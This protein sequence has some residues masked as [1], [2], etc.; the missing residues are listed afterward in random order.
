[1]KTEKKALNYKSLFIISI[2]VLTISLIAG[3]FFFSKSKKKEDQIEHGLREAK[4]SCFNCNNEVLYKDKFCSECGWT[5]KEKEQEEY[6]VQIERP[7]NYIGFHLIKIQKTSSGKYFVNWNFNAS[8]GDNHTYFEEGESCFSAEKMPEFL[9]EHQEC[10][11]NNDWSG[12]E[13]ELKDNH[14]LV[15]SKEQGED[16][17][18]KQLTQYEFNPQSEADRKEKEAE[19]RKQ[20]CEQRAKEIQAEA[21]KNKKNAERIKKECKERAEKWKKEHKNEWRT[22]SECGKNFCLETEGIIKKTWSSPN[23]DDPPKVEYFC[24][25]CNTKK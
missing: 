25:K 12:W 5:L 17:K 14:L 6:R 16:G 8:E 13:K 3:I 22:C 4:N 15:K 9:A 7:I 24:G 1:M 20:E 23:Y 18:F 11:E 19:Q 2:I 21:A 10:W